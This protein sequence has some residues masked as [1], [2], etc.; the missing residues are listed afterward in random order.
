MGSYF[1]TELSMNTYV[2]LKEKEGARGVCLLV[3][4]IFLRE[5][6]QGKKLKPFFLYKTILL[7]QSELSLLHQ[8]DKKT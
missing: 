5:K 6:T 3:V 4:G 2:E 8:K 1:S 7:V